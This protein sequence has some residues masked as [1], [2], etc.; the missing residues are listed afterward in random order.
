MENIHTVEVVGSGSR[1]PA[2]VKILTDFFK[3][4]PRRTMNASECVA[5]GCALE[6]AILSPTFK[7]R[8]FQ[9]CFLPWAM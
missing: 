4:E 9:V 5:R 8:E 6:C 2:V 1:V 3:K 7:V